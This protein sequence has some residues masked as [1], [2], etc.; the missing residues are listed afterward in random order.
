MTILALLNC[1]R[2]F[3]GVEGCKRAVEIDEAAS[4]RPSEGGGGCASPLARLSI[5][6]PLPPLEG[7]V[8]G[9]VCGT[10]AR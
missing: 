4:K 9:G 1:W 8:G 2:G 3:G 5:R 7:E 10:P 6:R